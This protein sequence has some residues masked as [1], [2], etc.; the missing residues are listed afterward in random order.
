L[1]G[2]ALR[3]YVP[4]VLLALASIGGFFVVAE[5]AARLSERRSVPEREVAF[6]KSA[7]PG[8]DYEFVPGARLPWAGREIRVNTLGFRGPE[9]TPSPS[10]PLRVAVLGDSIA[11]GYAVAE[12]EALPARL[13]EALAEGAIDAE[14]LGLGVPGYNIAHI[15]ALWRERA[16]HFG[17]SV[18]VYA[19]C[20]N[21]ALP[22]LTLT[23]EGRLVA[24]SVEL[25][26][27][28]AVPG[29][30]PVPGKRWLF[31][32]S[33]FYRFLVGRYDRALQRLGLRTP[34]LPPQERLDALYTDSPLGERFRAGLKAL[35][36]SVRESGATLVLA[37]FPTADQV[38][39]GRGGPQAA[40]AAASRELGVEFIDLLPAFR[41]AHPPGGLFVEDGL[42][43]SAE[44]HAIAAV[45]VAERLAAARPGPGS[46]PS[47]SGP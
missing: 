11:A 22:E 26:P 6:R 36:S 12:E 9:F 46:G 3:R 37:C 33:A 5:A 24:E 10:R 39:S 18:V 40:L 30:L 44:G 15:L 13:R 29:R 31:D 27:S 4:L 19:I 28:R 34:P 42:H 41:E 25:A 8:L 47:P 2:P 17:A 21:D 20:L 7:T 45:R 14:V 35:A 32:H 43:P 1:R 16:R 23:P 38:R